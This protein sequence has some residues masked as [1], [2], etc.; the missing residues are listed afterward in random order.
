MAAPASLL[1]RVVPIALIVGFAGVVVPTLD[2]GARPDEEYR[3]EVAARDCE[4]IAAALVAYRNDHGAYPPGLQNDP[5]Y[6]YGNGTAY[7]FSA[8]V[9]NAWLCKG[10]AHY[11]DTPIGRDP[12]GRA[13]NY[14]V[15]TR[16][17]AIADVVVFSNGP[18]RACDSWDS[19][20]WSLRRFRRD[21][22]GA[23]ADPRR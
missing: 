14:Q 15:F 8:E 7:G 18:D 20:C 3:R 17:A 4:R 22:V 9:L 16:S 2:R 12:W 23:F 21:D 13:F 11:L 6:N 19:G 10:R 5:T 1:R